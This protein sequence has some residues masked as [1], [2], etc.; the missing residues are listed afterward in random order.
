GI[1]SRPEYANPKALLDLRVRKALARAVDSPGIV[2]AVTGGHG[3]LTYSLTSPAASYYPVI[4]KTLVKYPYDPQAADQGLEVAGLS[5]GADGF[6]TQADGSPFKIQ[7]ATE[8][9]AGNERN[10]A[11]FVDSLRRAGIDASS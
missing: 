5:R 8:G 6:Y 3:L 4:E 1:Q 10:N 2:E 9:G 11:I 7:V